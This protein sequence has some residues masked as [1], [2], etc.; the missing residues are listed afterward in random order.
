[1]LFTII[2]LLA[3]T[4]STKVIITKP[5]ETSKISP[6]ETAGN[7]STV[8]AVNT[9]QDIDST[10]NIIRTTAQATT[11]KKV[12][13]DAAYIAFFFLNETSFEVFAKN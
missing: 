3:R 11:M 5:D 7:D 10:D 12:D 1:M 8:L 9:T 2:L 13:K 6:N 4:R